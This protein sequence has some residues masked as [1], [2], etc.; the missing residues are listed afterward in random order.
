MFEGISRQCIV[1]LHRFSVSVSQMECRKVGTGVRVRI[2]R[3]SGWRGLEGRG[4]WDL[5]LDRAHKKA[6]KREREV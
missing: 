4:G 5:S 2:D 6:N 1:S 3:G